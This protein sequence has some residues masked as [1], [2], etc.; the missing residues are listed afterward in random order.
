[1]GDAQFH[2][3]VAIEDMWQALEKLQDENN[4]IRPLVE[5]LV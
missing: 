3:N 2:H 5:K 1:M 4:N